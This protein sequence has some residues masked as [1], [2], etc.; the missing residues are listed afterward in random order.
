MY[1]LSTAGSH[2][3]L[4][5]LLCFTI[6][7]ST[8]LQAQSGSTEQW[9]I[10]PDISVGPITTTSSEQDLQRHYGRLQIVAADIESGEGFTET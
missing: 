10:V 9:L 2:E 8:N 6:V 7:F 1:R 4:H 3:N 5:R